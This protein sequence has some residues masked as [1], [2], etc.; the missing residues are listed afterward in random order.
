MPGWNK[1]DIVRPPSSKRGDV[2]IEHNIYDLVGKNLLRSFQSGRLTKG[3]LDDILKK[4]SL[5]AE[6]NLGKGYGVDL[7]YNV[8]SARKMDEYR[9]KFTKDLP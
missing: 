4:V 9:I 7:G 8:P 5:E 1:Q 6:I 2:K 3:Q